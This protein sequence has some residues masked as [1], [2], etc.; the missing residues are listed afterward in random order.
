M[1]YN[2]LIKLKNAYL[3]GHPEVILPY[4][5]FTHRVLEVLAR[6][7]YLGK[8]QVE[9]GEKRPFLRAELLYTNHTPHLREVRFRSKPGARIYLK[10][11]KLR[12]VRQG[13]GEVLVSTSKGVMTS[14]EA[15]RSNIGGEV[16]CEVF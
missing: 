16:I 12:G 13:Y 11:T 14:A 2:D 1:I 8:V 4:S 15:K 7:M 5:T 10:Q 3:A 6:K 9:E